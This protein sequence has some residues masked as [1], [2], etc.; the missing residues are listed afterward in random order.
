M[1]QKGFAPILILIIIAVLIGGYLIYQNSQNQSKTIPLPTPQL[2]S[3]PTATPESTNSA[4]TTNWKTYTNTDYGFSFQYP[5]S[6]Y[7]FDCSKDFYEVKPLYV[8][9]SD[10]AKDDCN[11]TYKA[12]LSSINVSV[13]KNFDKNKDYPIV[14]L[15]NRTEK[16]MNIGGKS[17]IQIIGT[18]EEVG[19]QGEK[20]SSQP[21]RTIN[22]TVISYKENVSIKITY[23]R[24]SS[25]KNNDQGFSVKPD[26]TGI[27][28]QIL[29]TFKFTQ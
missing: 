8:H 13:V 17:A 5:S 25:V 26:T 1:S 21:I 10:N 9:L 23:Q 27:F 7:L 24:I 15:N 28:D 18:Y 22:S 14:K 6:L 20:L 19:D 12:F 11:T 2:T 16:T 29:S 4:E 3:T